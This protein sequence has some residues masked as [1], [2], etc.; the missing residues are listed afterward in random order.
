[1][2]RRLAGKGIFQ[3]RF[4]QA[5]KTLYFP[6]LL[7]SRQC[8]GSI[9]NINWRYGKSVRQSLRIDCNVPLDS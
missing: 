6:I 4:Y 7:E 5:A 2:W 3:Q 9:G 8:S 1:M